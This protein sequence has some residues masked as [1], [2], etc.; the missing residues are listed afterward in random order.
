[1][2]KYNHFVSGFFANR[3]EAKLI[4]VTLIEHGVPRER[5]QLFHT[6]TPTH[7]PAPKDDSNAVLKDVLVDGIIG[8]AVG[9]GLGGLAEVALVATNVSLFIASPLLAPL[10]MMGWGASL[11]GLLGATIG[12]SKSVDATSAPD[13]AVKESWLSDLI[14]DSISN[15]Q[16]V[17]VV[18]AQSEQEAEVAR[19]VLKTAVGDYKEVAFA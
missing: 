2:A 9:T 18:N 8:T 11:G 5:L 13:D 3:E 10:V 19:K 14:R 15:G 7:S 4:G 6:D 16:T 17:L 12:A 1:M